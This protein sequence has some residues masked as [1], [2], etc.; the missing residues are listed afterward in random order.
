MIGQNR[1]L[2]SVVFLNL[3]ET[4]MSEIQRGSET[5]KKSVV[6]MVANL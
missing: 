6:S 1:S 4:N 5:I 2:G 3:L